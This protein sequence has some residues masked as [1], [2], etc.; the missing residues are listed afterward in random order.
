MLRKLKKKAKSK[1]LSRRNSFRFVIYKRM[2]DLIVKLET[3]KDSKEFITLGEQ[4][5]KSVEEQNDRLLNGKEWDFIWPFTEWD[6]IRHEIRYIEK[7]KDKLS[8][9]KDK[10]CR[11]ALIAD[12]DKSIKWR[13][14]RILGKTHELR[15]DSEDYNERDLNEADLFRTENWWIECFKNLPAKLVEEL[16]LKETQVEEIKEAEVQEQIDALAS[17]E[18]AGL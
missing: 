17:L 18:D 12:L 14:D 13:K 2:R 10:D 9:I 1:R 7:L 5:E 15:L 3:L 11:E 4:L 16:K 8:K 6:L